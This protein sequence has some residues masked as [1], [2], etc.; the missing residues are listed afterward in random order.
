MGA[1]TATVGFAVPGAARRGSGGGKSGGPGQT[2]DDVLLDEPFTVENPEVVTRNASCHSNQSER[3]EYN[4]Y[5][6]TYG[7]KNADG[8][9]GTFC[10]I[11]DEARL[12]EGRVYEFRSKQACKSSPDFTTRFS[13]GPSN[14]EHSC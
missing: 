12:N 3:V 8:D 1:G 5:E 14:S 2:S 4:K 10:V 11:P 13:F 7:D 9:G 6:Y